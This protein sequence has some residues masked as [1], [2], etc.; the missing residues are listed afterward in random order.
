[1]GKHFLPQAHLKRFTSCRPGFIYVYDIKEQRWR[2]PDPLP[3]SKVAQASGVWDDDTERRLER[4]ERPGL[5]ALGR[6]CEGETISRNERCYASLYLAM[7]M[8]VR[9]HVPWADMTKVLPY[10]AE[11]VVEQLRQSDVFLNA[12]TEQQEDIAEWLNE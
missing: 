3:I 12:S 7:M 1:M 8:G 2:S 4:V 9:S 6:L 10:E 11:K 5:L